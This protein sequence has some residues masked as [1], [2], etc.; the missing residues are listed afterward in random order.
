MYC[1]TVHCTKNNLNLRI[2]TEPVTAGR[3]AMVS[4]PYMQGRFL[5]GDSD[6]FWDSVQYNNTILQ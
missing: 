2:K 5:C 4:V 1:T 6:Y 3:D